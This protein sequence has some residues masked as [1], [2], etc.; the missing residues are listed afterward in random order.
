MRRVALLATL[1]TLAAATPALAQT[2]AVDSTSTRR[3]SVAATVIPAAG[4]Y[5]CVRTV[6]AGHPGGSFR[7]ESQGEL[8]LGV[9]GTYRFDRS[10]RVGRYTVIPTTRRIEWTG[11]YFGDKGR[12]DATFGTSGAPHV[13][14]LFHERDGDT[15]WV[16]ALLTARAPASPGAPAPTKP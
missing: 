10:N 1:A 5:N 11:G 3:D 6:W 7:F 13:E 14:V 16:C 12:L 2:A 8:T 9:D 4:T 15:R